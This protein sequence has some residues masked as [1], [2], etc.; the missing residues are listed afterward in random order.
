M[1]ELTS[2]V[3]VMVSEWKMCNS[4]KGTGGME[5]SVVLF[6]PR[7]HLFACTHTSVSN[8]LVVSKPF[9]LWVLV[10]YTHQSPAWSFKHVWL[11]ISCLSTRISLQSC[12]QTRLD[13]G[14]CLCTRTCQQPFVSNTVVCGCLFCLGLSQNGYG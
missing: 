12:V 3:R 13:S 8:S 11:G 10:A 5:C 9:E 6:K 14:S 7:I 2:L 4:N 1:C